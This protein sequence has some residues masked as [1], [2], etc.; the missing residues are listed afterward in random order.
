MERLTKPS[1]HGDRYVSAIGSGAGCWGKIVNRLAA[2]EDTGLTPFDI[3]MLRCAHD[4]TKQNLETAKRII[5]EW[6][7][8]IL[9]K[10]FDFIKNLLQAEQEGRLVVLPCKV[11]D[12]IYDIYE[13]MGN[14]IGGPIARRFNECKIH[15]DLRGKS[16]LCADGYIL[17]FDEFGETLFLTREEA[18]AALKGEGNEL[19]E[20]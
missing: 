9:D 5:A 4:A 19:V 12:T 1:R 6:D 13:A 10:G 17:A 11:G 14:G 3:E 18:E 2:Y 16:Y 15:I 8:I 7:A 20:S